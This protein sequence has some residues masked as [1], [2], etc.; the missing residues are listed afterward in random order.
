MALQYS[1]LEW[2]GFFGECCLEAQEKELRSSIYVT[3]NAKTTVDGNLRDTWKIQQHQY[4]AALTMK[5][6]GQDAQNFLGEGSTCF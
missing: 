3:C 2:G 1:E 6:V 4:L 5:R